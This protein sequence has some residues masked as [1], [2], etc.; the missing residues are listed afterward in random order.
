MYLRRN[1]VRCGAHRRTYVSIAHN[2]WHPNRYG[3]RGHSRPVVLANL[4]HED[5]IDLDTAQQ[6]VAVIERV[7]TRDDVPR[8]E[9]RVETRRLAR[10]IRRIEPALRLLAGRDLALIRQIQPASERLP[11]LEGLV[12]R[13]LS[14]SQSP[15]D[16]QELFG[17][18]GAGPRL[19]LVGS[20]H[21]P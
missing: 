2:V 8:G 1:T 13:A 4:G 5:Q 19:S 7:V 21:S 15:R 16:A 12:R 14:G 9:A 18:L 10:K 3:G 11:T 20:T 17:Q 6:L